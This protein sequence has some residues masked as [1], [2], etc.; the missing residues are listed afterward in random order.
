MKNLKKIIVT[1]AVFI[2]VFVGHLL[3]YKIFSQNSSPIWWKLYVVTQTYLISFSLAL[4]FAFGAYAITMM[5]N[6]SKSAVAGS[7]VIAFLVWFTSACGAPMIAIV[8]G[9]V[10]VGIGSTALPPLA[11]AVMT[12]VFISFGYLWLKRKSLSCGDICAAK[13]KANTEIFKDI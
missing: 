1:L 13:T 10:G 5:R 9:V 4:S 12:I 11:S 8:L 3:Y 6:R 2:A 7:A